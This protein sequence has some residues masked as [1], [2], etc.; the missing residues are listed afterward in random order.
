MAPPAI[1]FQDH[2]TYADYASWP[3][4]ERW[5]LIHGVAYNMT[6]APNT[7]HQ[8]ISGNLYLA[9]ASFLKGNSCDVFS[10]PFD[11]RLPQKGQTA[12]ETDT[13]VQPDISVFCDPSK[14]DG[15]GGIG[16]PDWVI[17]ILSPSTAKKDLNLKTLLYQAHGVKEYWIVDPE[18]DQLTVLRLEEKIQRYGI[19]QLYSG[20]GQ[21]SPNQFP[22][23][24]ISLAEIFGKE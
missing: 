12:E 19:P 21:V 17:E 7:R 15:K 23:L 11:V 4:E 14:L 13:V 20:E 9:I 8:R 24:T 5:E 6:P 10:A 16:A 18:L 22:K 2:Y 1:Y 3:E